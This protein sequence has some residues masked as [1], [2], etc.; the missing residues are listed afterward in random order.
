M[1]PAFHVALEV[2]NRCP[3]F[4]RKINISENDIVFIVAVEML[5]YVCRTWRSYIDILRSICIVGE[6]I[7][8]I[9]IRSTAC[10]F[11][12]RRTGA[13]LLSFTIFCRLIFYLI[14]F[15]KRIDVA[16]ILIKEFF[17]EILVI[18]FILFAETLCSCLSTYISKLAA[19]VVVTPCCTCNQKF[20]E[21]FS[22]SHFILPWIHT[23]QTCL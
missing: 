17:I 6:L 12:I 2:F 14:R 21:W 13:F 11:W 19:N 16:V 3:V 20:S 8:V 23:V 7:L 1:K 5:R 18:V 9:I 4:T 15:I 10:Q 22:F